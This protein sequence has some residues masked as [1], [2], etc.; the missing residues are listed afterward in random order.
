MKKIYVPVFVDH[1]T[2]SPP[3]P[4]FAPTPPPRPSQFSSALQKDSLIPWQAVHWKGWAVCKPLHTHVARQ[5]SPCLLTFPGTT[6]PPPWP[7]HPLLRLQCAQ[8]AGEPAG[9]NV[10][11]KENSLELSLRL[12]EHVSRFHVSQYI[13][14]ERTRPLDQHL[15]VVT[16]IAYLFAGL[17]SWINLHGKFHESGTVFCWSHKCLCLAEAWFVNKPSIYIHWNLSTLKF[18][19]HTGS[20]LH[21][22]CLPIKWING[23]EC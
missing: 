17:S 21:N 3:P 4:P 13:R 11:K 1:S 6:L 23:R 7:L 20:K 10:L 2:P 9:L 18:W 15:P 19:P 5:P 14:G 8:K 12:H 16:V 22:K